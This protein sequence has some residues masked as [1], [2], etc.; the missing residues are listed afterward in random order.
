MSK[1]FNASGEAEIKVDYS[2]TSLAVNTISPIANPGVTIDGDL[3]VDGHLHYTS[4]TSPFWA[5][6]RVN[7]ISTT[8]LTSKGRQEF[9]DVRLQQGYYKKRWATAHTDGV[10]YSVIAQGEDTGSKWSILDDASEALAN[11][12]TSVTVITQK[13]SFSITDGIINYAVLA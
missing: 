13:N 8:I 7:G 3:F 1:G 9:A 2:S 4:L 6:G 11:T 5:A 10:Y 12:A